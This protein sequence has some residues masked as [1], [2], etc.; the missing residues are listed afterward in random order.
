MLHHIEKLHLQTKYEYN[1]AFV[2]LDFQYWG[3]EREEHITCTW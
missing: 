3:R 1:V 2:S